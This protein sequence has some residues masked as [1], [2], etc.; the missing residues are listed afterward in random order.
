MG[1]HLFF[2]FHIFT[3]IIDTSS[4][5]FQCKIQNS[6]DDLKKMGPHR[7]WS[8]LIAPRQEEK[9]QEKHNP[10]SA[11]SKRICG[12]LKSPKLPH[13]HSLETLNLDIGWGGSVI[14][15][16][17]ESAESTQSCSVSND[18]PLWMSSREPSS[19]LLW[20]PDLLVQH[21]AGSMPV[22]TCA[23]TCA[24]PCWVIGSKVPGPGLCAWTREFLDTPS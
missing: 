8:P 12:S 4:F 7:H 6:W 2:V 5:L 9:P 21:W 22:K 24:R 15:I 11:A 18:P 17:S 10:E 16:G 20:V 14:C 1:I 23:A 13:P 3:N 19:L